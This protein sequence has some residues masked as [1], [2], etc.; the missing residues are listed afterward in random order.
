MMGDWQEISGFVRSRDNTKQ[1]TFWEKL[2]KKVGTLDFRD[3]ER[4]C[5]IALVK[6]LFPK[7]SERAI[8][9]DV[10]STNWPSTVYMAALPWVQKVVDREP[11][12]ASEYAK[13]VKEAQPKAIRP[14]ISD[15]FNISTRNPFLELDGNFYFDHTLESPK[16]T[17]LKGTPDDGSREDDETQQKRKDLRGSLK[18]IR[19]KIGSSPSPYYALLLMDG[20][21]MGKLF[22]EQK[23]G[24]ENVSRALGAFTGKV[25]ETVRERNGV[26]VY[27]GGDDVL[28]LL[29]V[30]G[31][32][33][34][35]QALS[36]KFAKLFGERNIK[37]T[38]S[39]GLIFTHY[40]V[41]LKSVME[42]AHE[43]LD[44][45]A[46]EKNGRDSIAVSVLKP[47]GKYAQW[48]TTWKHFNSGGM[49]NL[50]KLV[51]MFRG[52][53]DDR[54]LSAS[55]IYRTRDT[56]CVL[57]KDSFWKPGTY[58]DLLEGLDATKL[59]AA[60]YKR[61]MGEKVSI[62]RAEEV[63][64]ELLDISYE[65]NNHG[66]DGEKHIC[67]DAMML[68]KFLAENTMEGSK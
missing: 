25:A 51:S 53:G 48:V 4:L 11:E 29:P 27:T 45:I 13:Q 31:A 35:A 59:L 32:L 18:I 3:D 56:F 54:Q 30:P 2:R 28:A 55:F 24:G 12:M 44:D 57:A 68:V 62:D 67:V 37:G 41:P 7:V 16:L 49:N 60:D 63:A 43:M 65:Y 66:N 36:E 42:E 34:C 6:R 64:G 23:D 50:E 1:K 20:D 9:W 38:I 22:G 14:G 61:S 10:K 19:C 40:H 33:P 58:F 46:K 17:P 47:S 5:A 52:S 8:E 15:N 21:N 39:A 26:T